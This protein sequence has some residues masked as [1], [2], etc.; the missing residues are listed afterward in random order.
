M[1]KPQVNA[2]M[3]D[4][5]QGI[6]TYMLEFLKEYKLGNIA[7]SVFQEE[8]NATLTRLMA[9][10]FFKSLFI[11][12]NDDK[13]ILFDL[14]RTDPIRACIDTVRACELRTLNKKGLNMMHSA[15]FEMINQY[16]TII[17]EKVGAELHGRIVEEYL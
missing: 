4:P 11:L 15:M 12:T 6:T 13:D 16:G 5:R 2:L 9:I 17:Y 10:K 7:L 14:V 1:C 8:T 3:T